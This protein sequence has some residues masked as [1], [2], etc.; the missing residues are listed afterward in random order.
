[1]DL[2]R[3]RVFI[4]AAQMLSFSKTAQQQHVSQPTVSKYIRD[5]ES[6]L[7]VR[8][9]DRSGAG[10]SLT[11]AGRALL[12][13]ANHLLMEY[14]KFQDL[15]KSLESDVGG[16]IRIACTTAAGK[17][18]LPHL[19]ARFRNLHPNVQVN[20]LSCT[21]EGAI[22]LMLEEEA[23]LGVVSYEVVSDRLES[24]FFFTDHIILIVSANH[25]WADRDYIELSEILEEP[26]IMRESTS[27]TRRALLTELACHD[28]KL[29]DLKVILEVGNS[30]AIVSAV[31]AGIG[32]SFVSRMSAIPFLDGNIVVDLPI[33]GVSLD[34]RIFI[35]RR[36]IDT[37]NRARDVFWGF[38]HDPINEDLYQKTHYQS[39]E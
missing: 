2:D 20:I 22:E 17:Y 30:E 15:A 34:R 26:L 29:D 6:E 33:Q 38:I 7:S 18:I 23:D 31:S 28:I 36:S 8:L 3:L 37:P 10:L 1:M 19:A 4:E 9:F 27:G 32:I 24:Q 14:N 13:A 12:P 35:A 11:E 25:P 39:K 16:C 21:Q 5:L